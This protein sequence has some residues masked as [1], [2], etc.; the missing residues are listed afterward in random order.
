MFITLL[1]VT[2]AIS[3][4]VATAVV[5]LFRSAL[6]VILARLVTEELAFAWQRYMEFA[7]YVVGVSGGVRVWELEKYITG[8][9]RDGKAVELNTDRWVLEVYRTIIR[10]AAEHCLDALG[11]LRLCADRVRDHAGIRA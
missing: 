5:R 7:I 8:R 1:L 6:A 9:G 11:L 4:G 3:I 2:F 10:D